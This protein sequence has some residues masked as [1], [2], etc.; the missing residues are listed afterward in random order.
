MVVIHMATTG[1]PT[2]YRNQFEK[3]LQRLTDLPCE[4]DARAIRT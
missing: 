1:D 4:A 3:E 2:G